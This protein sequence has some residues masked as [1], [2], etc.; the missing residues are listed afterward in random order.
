LEATLA[1]VNKIHHIAIVVE[2]MDQALPFWQDTLG[3]TVSGLQDIAKEEA[4]VGFLPL[5]DS[6]IELIVP[7]SND[8]GLAKFLAKRGPGLHHL[9][10]EVDD[11]EA[12][13]LKLKEKNVRLINDQPRINQEGRRYIFIHP[14]STNGVLVELYEKIA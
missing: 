14:E 1:S 10:L 12:F 6:E 8:S 7:T 5:G 2:N 4:Q 13:L 3:I 11:L 9:C